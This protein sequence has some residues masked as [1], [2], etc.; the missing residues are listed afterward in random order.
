MTVR[1]PPR[2]ALFL[3]AAALM[4]VVRPTFADK[5]PKYVGGISLPV[6]VTAGLNP[7]MDNV[8]SPGAPTPIHPGSIG[9]PAVAGSS[10]NGEA[11]VSAAKGTRANV[12]GIGTGPAKPAGI[13]KFQK[14]GGIGPTTASPAGIGY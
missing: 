4:L 5:G 3:A 13:N 14:I 7:A 2:P 1:L 10:T 12:G 8:V 6:R 9:M 11:V